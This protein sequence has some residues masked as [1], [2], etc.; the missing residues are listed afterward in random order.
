MAPKQ[1]NSTNTQN[2]LHEIIAIRNTMQLAQ[3]SLSRLEKQ[4]A[5]ENKKPI[6]TTLSR[7]QSKG[8][9]VPPRR[10]LLN[11]LY[12]QEISNQIC[13][14]HQKFG[15]AANISN[16][17]GPE[18][19]QFIPPTKITLKPTMDSKN[20]KIRP[21]SS[22]PTAT[23]TPESIK[24]K[25]QNQSNE[26]AIIPKQEIWTL[27][28]LG[29]RND[30][31]FKGKYLFKSTETVYQA[32][33]RL[34][35][36][37]C[38]FEGTCPGPRLTTSDAWVEFLES[39]QHKLIISSNIF[40]H[41]ENESLDFREDVSK[42]DKEKLNILKLAIQC[43]VA[44]NVEKAVK[45]EEF[46]ASVSRTYLSNIEAYLLHDI[47]EHAKSRSKALAENYNT[48]R[49]LYAEED[50]LLAT[51]SGGTYSSKMEQRLDD[52]LEASRRVRDKIGS[53]AEQWHTSANLLK[54]S[55]KSAI[56][57]VECWNLVK[58][59]RNAK[60][61]ISQALDSRNA[62]AQSI[63]ALEYS[64]KALP[65]V[66]FYHV[67][68]RQISAIKH[69]NLYLLTDLANPVRYDHTRRVLET[70]QN[71]LSLAVVWL[72]DTFN[73][74]LRKDFNHSED[75]VTSLAKELRHERLEFISRTIG[76]SLYVSAETTS[77]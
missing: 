70:F 11:R 65:H 33:R 30:S 27:T 56:L 52:Q 20:T 25:V 40:L 38:K 71:N 43:D 15:K 57:A 50:G 66:D 72:F 8:R 24:E 63:V 36:Q 69:A 7:E 9:I 60:E 10:A 37:I 34:D 16:C 29:P 77:K 55:A 51:V 14:Y 18:H 73:K 58:A 2:L 1:P 12:N 23:T 19:C 6:D 61:R 47:I 28:S 59:S 3:Q 5:K 75:N 32:Y 17:P 13:W 22:N 49:L 45:N 62:V 68:P 46:L 64:Q 42:M 53:V 21:A 48:L 44:F 26:E 41:N 76:T 31:S 4:L 35:Q 54:T 39:E 74:T 67:T